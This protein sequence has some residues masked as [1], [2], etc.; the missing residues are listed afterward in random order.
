MLP[1]YVLRH[2]SPQTFPAAPVTL[3]SHILPAKR[4]LQRS[5]VRERRQARQAS[6][7]GE[8][9]SLTPPDAGPAD[10]PGLAHRPKRGERGAFPALAP[11]PDEAEKPVLPSR[12]AVHRSFPQLQSLIRLFCRAPIAAL[13]PPEPRAP[14]R[15]A[16]PQSGRRMEDLA[17]VT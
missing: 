10:Q 9:L 3:S 13:Q 15:V 1:E 17:D 2:H 4:V 6:V 12:P 5:A 14:A 16:Q 11:V 7:P 8:K